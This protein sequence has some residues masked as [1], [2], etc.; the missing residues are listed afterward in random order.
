MMGDGGLE[1]DK[2]RVGN[3]ILERQDLADPIAADAILEVNPEKRLA[4]PDHISEPAGRPEGASSRL[5]MKCG[6]PNPTNGA[7]VRNEAV[8]GL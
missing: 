4:R 1:F 5:I 2:P 8:I 6:I 3:R 7:P